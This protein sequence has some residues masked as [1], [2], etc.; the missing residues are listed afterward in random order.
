[1]KKDKV[2]LRV[3]ILNAFLIQKIGNNALRSI[4]HFNGI[5]LKFLILITGH[6]SSQ[7]YNIQIISHVRL[8]FFSQFRSR[9]GIPHP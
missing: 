5:V 1:M 4:I 2:R 3:Q 7:S 9:N 8:K 6:R